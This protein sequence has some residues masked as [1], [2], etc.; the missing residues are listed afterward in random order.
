MPH[1]RS[2]CAAC[3]G[4]LREFLNLGSSPLADRF[5]LK[6]GGEGPAYPLA[7]AYCLDC[8]LAQL[9]CVVD[10]AELFGEDYGFRTAGS[11]SLV[12]Y[13]QQ[14]ADDALKLA[15]GP[16]PVA[17]I[18]CNDGTLLRHFRA[19]GCPV[20]GVDPSVAGLDAVAAGIELYPQVFTPAVAKQIREEQGSFRLVTAINVAAHVQDPADFLRAVRILLDDED[21]LAII[22]FQDLEYLIAGCMFD[23]VYHEHR[24]FYSAATFGHVAAVAGLSLVQYTHTPGQGGSIRAVLKRSR[25]VMDFMVPVSRLASIQ[26]LAGLQRRA[27]FSRD[28]LLELLDRPGVVAGYGATAKSATLLNYCNIGPDLV[29]YVEDTTPGKIGR[30]TPGTHIPIVGPG[31]HRLPDIFLLL[32]WNYLGDILRRETV[33]TGLGG[34]FIIPGPVP[35]VI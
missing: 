33:F 6:P 35:F 24:F 11:P 9:T 30:F 5:P 3:G 34:K 27:E 13:Y 1:V 10:D 29:P 22:E 23:H 7:A 16:V 19:A 20:L 25:D 8:S 18:G 2:E 14:W 21:G 4:Q 32:A 28:V 12:S 26:G 31:E 17:D 15:G